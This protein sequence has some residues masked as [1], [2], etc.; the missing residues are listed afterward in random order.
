[1]IDKLLSK[2]SIRGKLILLILPLL[3]PATVGYITYLFEKYKDIDFTR[4][5][6]EGA[7]CIKEVKEL[8]QYVQNHTGKTAEY[9]GT[10][11]EDEKNRI[12]QGIMAIRDDIKKSMELV[13]S[14]CSYFGDLKDELENI[15]SRWSEIES[16]VFSLSQE[17]SFKIHTEY[18][19]DLVLLVSDISDISN[20]AFDPEYLSHYL[21]NISSEL[22]LQFIENI[23]QVRATTAGISARGKISRQEEMTVAY[24]IAI[25][26]RDYGEINH[27]LNKIFQRF[28]SE[29]RNNLESRYS[30]F[31][32]DLLGILDSIEND[33]L[34]GDE[35]VSFDSSFVF[36]SFTRAMKSGYD[37]FDYTNGL[38]ISELSGR[39]RGIYGSVAFSS[40]LN[41][42]LLIAALVL[43][44][45][46]SRNIV[47][48]LEFMSLNFL[49]I[50]RGGADL[51]MRLPVDSSDEIGDLARY[52]NEFLDSFVSIIRTIG[53]VSN[54]LGDVGG[55]VKSAVS[56]SF[57]EIEKE[58]QMISALSTATEELSAVS[59]DIL[60]STH[61]ILDFNRRMEEESKE[62]GRMMRTSFEGIRK[63]GEEFPSIVSFVEGIVSKMEEIKGV[64][65]VIEDVADQ[66]NLLALNA[67]IEAA[68]AGEQGRGFAVVAEEVRKLAQKTQSES[69]VIRK[70]IEEFENTLKTVADKIESFNEEIRSYYGRATE[71]LSKTEE[72]MRYVSESTRN[73]SAIGTAIEEQNKSTEELAR[74]TS[75]IVEASERIKEMM[76]KVNRDVSV[77]YEYAEKLK[78]I[79]SKFKY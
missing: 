57:K 67:A 50:A 19:G 63:M 47:S 61:K 43:V 17:E 54:T 26:R 18:I 56:S 40:T 9:L 38:L 53:D 35:I 68:R 20:L 41:L 46:I 59:S 34:D 62:G 45:L 6:I 79:V 32:L 39:L 44:F 21:W 60:K 12:R 31:S 65:G 55:S 5:E 72:I 22:L 64:I 75:N 16:K 76:G 23:G 13:F 7:K 69:G 37:L 25:V 4:K 8:I 73:V 42:G 66:T 2:M 10:V 14:S 78:E 36:D 24:L 33:F 77:L 70:K 30:T 48:R 71:G 15:R 51:T 52:F 58:G 29:V 49:K 1:M 27:K 28:P 3:G 11:D 74:N